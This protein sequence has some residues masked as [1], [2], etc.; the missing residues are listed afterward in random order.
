MSDIDLE[1]QRDDKVFP[2]AREVL[3][4][5]AELL[6][7][8]NANEKVDYNPIVLKTLQRSLDADF[9]IT[10]EA[11]YLFQVLLGAFAG[12]NSTVQG[13]TALPIDD[14]RYGAISKR[15]LTLLAEA[16][17][18][19]GAVTPE[20]TV[21]DFAPIQVK[22]NAILAE[23][24]LSMLEVKYIMDNIFDS[25]NAVN[26]MYSAQIEQSTAAAEAKLFG[27][28]DMSDL[29]LKRLDEVLKTVEAPVAVD[30]TELHT[31]GADELPAEPT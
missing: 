12:L 3:K 27:I 30:T 5:M 20:Q 25:F 15:I 28:E 31:P 10:M 8:E 7:P 19:L 13:C 2:I 17:I 4:D 16:P 22:I 24:K 26:N 1:K 18:R 23:E 29:G 9:N 11:Q 21:E 14:V 6:I